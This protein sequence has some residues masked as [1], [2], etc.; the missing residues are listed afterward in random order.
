MNEKCK[1]GDCISEAKNLIFDESGANSIMVC[2]LHK[3][4][5]YQCLQEFGKFRP[6][7]K[8]NRAIPKVTVAP[9]LQKQ[10]PVLRPDS[11]IV[12]IQAE[13]DKEEKDK[14]KK[15]TAGRGSV[16]GTLSINSIPKPRKLN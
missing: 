16:K 5:V 4:V 13:K 7:Q 14:I 8:G 11:N 9:E 12:D 6:P 1:W 2:N 10:A 15:L 3:A